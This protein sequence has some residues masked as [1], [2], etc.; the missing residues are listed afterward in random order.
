MSLITHLYSYRHLQEC[1]TLILSERPI[2]MMISDK[3]TPIEDFSETC[4][5]IDNEVY[6]EDEEYGL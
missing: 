5:L 3:I 1:K 4:K 2:K 6:E